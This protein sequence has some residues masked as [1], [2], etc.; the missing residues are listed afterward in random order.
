MKEYKCKKCNEIFN[1]NDLRQKFCSKSCAVSFNNRLRIVSETT[2]KKIS[3]TLSSKERP[4]VTKRLSLQKHASF[5]RET[6]ITTLYDLSS[7][8]AKKILKR[9][10]LPCSNC[11][12]YV[13]DVSCDIHHIIPRKEGGTD[14]HDNLTYICPNCHRLAHSDKIKSD[15]LTSLSEYIG[16]K[17]KEFY[18]VKHGKLEEKIIMP[19]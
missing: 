19:V 12:W 14:S 18:Y 8:T 7:R 5:V 11:G 4:T 17:W 1:P 2:K 3:D 6:E 9:M 13:E 16:D 10:K 15:T